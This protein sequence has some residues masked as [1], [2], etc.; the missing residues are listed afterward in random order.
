MHLQQA[1]VFHSVSHITFD[2]TKL[3]S[4]FFTTAQGRHGQ[5]NVKRVGRP[6]QQTVS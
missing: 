4:P 6:E 3:S 1:Q 2:Q 5:I